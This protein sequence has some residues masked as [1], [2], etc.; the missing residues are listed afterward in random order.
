MQFWRSDYRRRQSREQL[1]QTCKKR[2][3][4]KT[5][6]MLDGLLPNDH[7]VEAHIR[8]VVEY[9]VPSNLKRTHDH[10]A[11]YAREYQLEVRTHFRMPYNRTAVTVFDIVVLGDRLARTD[12]KH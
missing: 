5:I 9:H 6:S 2:T 7:H 4:D 12:N 10:D 3:V 8:S 11:G 1:K